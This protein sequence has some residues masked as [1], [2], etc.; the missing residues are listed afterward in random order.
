MLMSG[1]TWF[2]VRHDLHG[3]RLLPEVVRQGGYETFA[4][5][6]WHNGEASFIRAF[7]R[8]RSVFFGGM[9]D[10]TKVPVADVRTGR[11][12][13]RRIAAKFSSEQFA[14]A[15]VEF[16]RSRSG[17]GPFFCYVAFTAPHDPRNPPKSF[18]AMYYGIRPSL[19]E[20][21]LP[22]HPF[23]NG[24]L[25]D[26]RDE[27]LAP[28][29]RTRSVLLPFSDLMRS[30]RDTRW[31]LIVYPQINHRQLFDLRD[32]PH[33]TRDLAAEPGHEPE[34]ARLTALMRSSQ[35]QF[36]DHQPLTVAHPK[37]TNIRFDDFDRKP[38][39]W[40]ARRFGDHRGGG[41]GSR[42]TRTQGRSAA[43]SYFWRRAA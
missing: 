24:I 33:E 30:V 1:R 29:P 36:G 25:K 37:P 32:D 35:E 8:G 22:Q 5:D 10:H 12:V 23:D 21:F 43:R 15:A 14:D 28:Y 42:G 16:L 41:S 2:D 39:E 17:G 20:N 13:D 3:V 34:I 19:P 4:T 26:I 6:K 31:K 11:V 9:A 40:F 18:R 7:P 27:K 38:D